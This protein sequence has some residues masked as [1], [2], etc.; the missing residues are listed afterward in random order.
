MDSIT[1]ERHAVRSATEMRLGEWS[2]HNPTLEKTLGLYTDPKATVVT[3][4]W[5]SFVASG[6][7]PLLA[8]L[9]LTKCNNITETGITELVREN[10]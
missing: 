8:S 10:V 9:D 2:K 7:F 5:L 4:D 3:D 6:K 1:I